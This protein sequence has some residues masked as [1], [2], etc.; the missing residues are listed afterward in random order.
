MARCPSCDDALTTTVH[1]GVYVDLCNDCG[2]TWATLEQLEELHGG[3]VAL[4]L[5]KGQSRHRC[6][7]CQLTLTRARLDGRLDVETCTTCRG[8][9]FEEG[10]LSRFKPLKQALQAT[11]MA[12]MFECVACGQ[13]FAKTEGTARGSGLSCRPCAGLAEKPEQGPDAGDALAEWM[14]RHWMVILALVGVAASLA[15]IIAQ[16]S[17][18]KFLLGLFSPNPK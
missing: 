15:V 6:A 9:F 14:A 8:V 4:K 18:D 16:V 17:F 7:T 13:A 2:A 3:P 12:G 5:L 11:R 10:G 1:D